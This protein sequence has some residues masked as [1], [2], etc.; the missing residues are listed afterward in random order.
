MPA[1]VEPAIRE[2]AE[3]VI[4]GGGS[5]RAADV[6]KVMLDKGSISTDEINDLGYNHPPRAIGDV[7]DAGVPVI[8]GSGTSP[9]SGRRMAIYSLGIAADIQEGRVGG[10]SALPKKFKVALVVRYGSVDCITG[11]RLDERVLQIDHRVPYRIAGD[12]G[13]S[14][15]NV[16]VYMLLDASSQRAKSWSCENCPNMLPANRSPAVCKRCFWA[17]PEDYDHIATLQLRRTDVAWQDQDVGVHDKLKAI[18]AAQGL[19]VADILRQLARAKVN[20][21]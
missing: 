14:D 11:A 5:K 9:R 18:A 4:S 8:T 17:Y 2:L 6:L 3:K 16:E 12:A 19:T 10:R 21:G 7:R 1:D 20:S 13:L 15:H